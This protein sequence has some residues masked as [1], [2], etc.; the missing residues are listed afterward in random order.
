MSRDDSVELTNFRVYH[1]TAKALLIGAADC[2]DD[3]KIWLPKSLIQD[4]Y[5]FT[6]QLKG[7]VWTEAVARAEVGWI[8]V[9]KWWAEQEDLA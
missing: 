4:H 5:G 2:A 3:D 8:D 1:E 6:I 9:P 7:N